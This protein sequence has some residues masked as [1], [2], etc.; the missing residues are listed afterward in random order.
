MIRPL[1][2]AA[3]SIVSLSL[4]AKAQTNPPASPQLVTSHNEERLSVDEESNRRSASPQSRAEAKRLYKQGVKYGRAGLFQQAAEL[5]ERT[6]ALD[7]DYNVAYSGLGHAYLDLGEWDKAIEALQTFLTFHPKD[8]L[9]KELLAQAEES[10][11]SS[12]VTEQVA[13]PE[14]PQPKV[15][16]RLASLSTASTTT[17]SSDQ[18]NPTAIYK[19]GAGDVLDVRVNGAKAGSN[20]FT[21]SPTGLLDH[22]SLTEP[23][24]VVGLTVEEV[25]SRFEARMKRRALDDPKVSIGINDYASHT[26]LVSG[27]VKESGTKVLRREALPLYVVIADAQPLPEASRLTLVRNNSQETI[28]LVDTDRLNV[29]VFP[30]DVIT[31]LPELDQFFYMTG[32]V[33][34][35]GEKKYRQGMTLTQALI[36]AG[37]V[38]DKAKEARVSRDRG[39][40]FLMVTKYKLKDIHS[41]KLRDPSFQPGDRITIVD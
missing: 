23:L 10:K 39:D 19:I 2:L 4:V 30:G 14:S 11:K 33:V 12:P 13:N 18:P 1:V 36:V 29:L 40:G 26:I 15:R 28:S 27:L 3:L 21:I 17:A 8:S 37:G 6:L 38:T 34:S 41:G 32:E 22:P 24:P 31:L 20:L 35:P 5:F 7:P 9:A 16:A 25:T